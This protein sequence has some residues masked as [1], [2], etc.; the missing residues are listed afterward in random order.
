MAESSLDSEVIKKTQESLGKFVKKP[1]LTEKLLKK[2]PF[3]FIHDVIKVVK[4]KKHFTVGRVHRCFI[5]PTDVLFFCYF[6][7]PLG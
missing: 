2:P 5:D 4:T 1:P 3:K 6:R 7:L